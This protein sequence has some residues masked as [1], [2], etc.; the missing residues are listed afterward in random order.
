MINSNFKW[1]GVQDIRAMFRIA[2]QTP[3][4]DI[5]RAVSDAYLFDV[6][7]KMGNTLLTA[8]RAVLQEKHAHWNKDKTYAE[9]AITIYDGTYWKCLVENTNSLP[10]TDNTNWAELELLTFWTNYI[11]PYFVA[12]AYKR[13]L[14][15]HGANATQFGLTEITVENSEKVSDKR[16]AE[17]LADVNNKAEVYNARMNK[18]FSDTDG[19]F[20]GT[21]YTYDDVDVIRPQ[22][23]PQILGVGAFNKSKRT[24]N[25]CNDCQE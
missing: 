17:L 6:E 23:G 8:V 18:E 21:T 20:D 10:A 13:W 19:E 25:G 4:P 22:S 14:L 5:D 1:L 12:S 9:D 15:W 7:P 16:R 11:R 3:E 2:E 24:Y